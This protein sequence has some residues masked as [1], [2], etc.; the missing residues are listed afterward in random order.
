VNTVV[1]AW[2]TFMAW[3]LVA[4]LALITTLAAPAAMARIDYG[5]AEQKR[6]AAAMP[7][8]T[9]VAEPMSN[10]SATHSRLATWWRFP[11]IPAR[12]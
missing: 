10:C 2:R 9:E 11:P 3:R 6:I 12:R 5:D 4:G 1:K 7:A 8:V